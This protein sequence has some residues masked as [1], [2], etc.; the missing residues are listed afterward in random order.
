V[1]ARVTT[2]IQFKVCGLTSAADA[3]LAAGVGASHLGFNLYP[4]SPRHLG[5]ARYVEIASALPRLPRVAILVEPS[6]PEL[7]ATLAAG[8]DAIQIHFRP[9]I[10]AARL[11]DWSS[12]VGPDRLWLAPKRPPG[13]PFSSLWLPLAETFLF[14]SYS[15]GVFGG[16]GTT[17]DWSG[18]AE[19]ARAHQG[20]R[21]ILAGGLNPSNVAAAVAASGA[22][23]VDVAS[24][25]E[26]SPGVKDPAKLAAFAA[27]LAAS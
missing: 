3:T 7:A 22:A 20:H 11:A 13:S 4:K 27:A 2:S 26:S 23:F 24:G 18:F 25:V 14:D 12:K 21:W 1:G 10:D 15:E 19:L 17:G 9:E 16:S 6:R 5:L 8:F